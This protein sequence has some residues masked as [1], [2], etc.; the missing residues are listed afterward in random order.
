[1]D[2]GES[3][4]LYG[5]CCRNI[6]LQVLAG[7]EKVVGLDEVIGYATEPRISMGKPI[8]A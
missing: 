1:M 8:I 5:R 7:N 4:F 6:K 2:L 3:I